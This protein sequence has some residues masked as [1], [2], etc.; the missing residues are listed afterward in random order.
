LRASL[1]HVAPAEP[2]SPP[3]PEAL[4][5]LATARPQQRR[6]RVKA[7]P[8]PELERD[9]AAVAERFTRAAFLPRAEGRVPLHDLRSAYR[10]WCESLKQTPLPDRKIGP[11][12]RDLFSSVEFHFEGHGAD[13]VVVGI[14]WKPGSPGA[15]LLINGD[16]IDTSVRRL[17][18]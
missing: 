16:G 18:A 3:E 14:E 17:N 7:L 2:L 8:K 4:P 1:L 12:L 5:A 15:P 6:S 9:A 11:A 10:T 13:T